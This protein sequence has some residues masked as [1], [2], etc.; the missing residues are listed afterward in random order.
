MTENTASPKKDYS[1][2][3]NELKKQ[4]HKIFNQARAGSIHT[5]SNYRNQVLNFATFLA[6]N[7]GIQKMANIQDKHIHAY[8]EDL[9]NRGSSPNTIKTYLSGIRYFHDHAPNTRYKISGNEEFY[10]EQR[11]TI[12]SNKAWT[13]EEYE[14]LQSLPITSDIYD[15]KNLVHDI[16]CLAR[17]LGLRISEATKL[18]TSNART[19][20]KVGTLR[21]KGKGGKIRY[22]PLNDEAKAV[23]QSRLATVE[24]GQKL[25]V[26]PDEKTHLAIQRVQ[27]YLARNRDKFQNSVERLKMNENGSNV[28][29]G[30]TMHGLRHMYVREQFEAFKQEGYTENQAKL[31]VSKLI[32]HER[33]EVTNIYIS[34]SKRSS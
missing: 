8:V 7:F 30:L 20:L 28:T 2:K 23:L 34:E 24:R 26:R 32:G 1:K 22:V 16:S 21:V 27:N 15:T 4:V 31:K 12:G 14:K 6:N 25:F 3:A 13:E 9:K 10:T 18:D 29:E 5:K 17:N 19:A 11:D 33:K